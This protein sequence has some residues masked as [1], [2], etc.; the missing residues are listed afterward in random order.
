VLRE[1]ELL[2]QTWHRLNLSHDFAN[3]NCDALLYLL[4]VVPVREVLSIR[5]ITEVCEDSMINEQ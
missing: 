3:H 4:T 5:E 1:R 2:G